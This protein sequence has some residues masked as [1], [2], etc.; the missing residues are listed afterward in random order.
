MVDG[1]GV[2][3]LP[4]VAAEGAEVELLSAGTGEEEQE[5]ASE[6][7]ASHKDKVL[8]SF[9]AHDN[10][11]GGHCRQQSAHR[12]FCLSAFDQE[13]QS[14]K[15]KHIGDGVVIARRG[16]KERPG[17]GVAMATVQARNL[18]F[19]PKARWGSPA[20]RARYPSTSCILKGSISNTP[21]LPKLLAQTARRTRPSA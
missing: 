1:S 11:P 13:A 8:V 12:Q 16:G 10:I 4:V 18:R 6:Y 17:P 19:L 14:R 2:E 3:H 9:N 5:Q 20:R 15:G 7:G 21:P